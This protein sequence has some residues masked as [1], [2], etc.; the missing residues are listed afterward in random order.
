MSVSGLCQICEARPAEYRCDACGTL[1]CE[2]HFERERGLC[3]DCVARADPTRPA[4]D[5][6]VD[7]HRF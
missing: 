2:M 4:D 3:A 1:A 7:V 6:D 5:E